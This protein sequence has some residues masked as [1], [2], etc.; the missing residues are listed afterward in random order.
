MPLHLIG[1]GL[2][3]N[4]VRLDAD[5]LFFVSVNMSVLLLG[6]HIYSDNSFQFFYIFNQI[7][8]NSVEANE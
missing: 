6:H 2:L 5:G 3:M 8:L 4:V 7:A 1:V